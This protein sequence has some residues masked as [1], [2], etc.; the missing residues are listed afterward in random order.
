MSLTLTIPGEPVA[1]GRPRAFYRPGLGVR[2]FDPSKSRNWKATAQEHMLRAIREGGLREP[3][4]PDGPV[5]LRILAVFTCPRSQWKKRVPLLRRPKV[6]RPDA[7]NIAKAVQDAASGVL[8]TD[9]AQVT[10]LTVEKI[11]GAQGEAPGVTVT[12]EAAE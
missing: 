7:E 5:H 8:F 4:V 2:V 6:G 11:V 12:V 10:R 3:L 9:D 1:Q